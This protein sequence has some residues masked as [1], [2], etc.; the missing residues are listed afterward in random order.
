VLNRT[1]ICERHDDFGT[2]GWRPSWQPHFDAYSGQA[3]PHDILEHLPN[4]NGGAEAEFMALGA[5]WVVRGVTGWFA[6]KGSPHRAPVHVAA[7]LED[8]F[9]RIYDGEQS[10]SDPGPT[11]PLRDTDNEKFVQD[12][13]RLLHTNVREEL[14]CRFDG[15]RPTDDYA[16]VDDLLSTENQRRLAGWLRRG[17]RAACARYRKIDTYGLIYMF[18]RISAEADRLLK[19]AEL[20]D[21]LHISISL[22]NMKERVW[23]SE[24]DLSHA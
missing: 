1:F 4:D 16:S 23:I 11:R 9:G 24:R 18:D 21:E 10:I 3:I 12:V 19:D 5:M 6:M 15:H 22:K 13:L 17:I 7:D 2:N 14:K 8:I 20:G